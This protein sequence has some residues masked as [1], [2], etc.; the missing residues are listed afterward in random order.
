MDFLQVVALFND[1]PSS[2]KKTTAPYT[3]VIDGLAT[4]LAAYTNGSDYTVSQLTI[5]NA[6]YGWL[7]VWGLIFGIPRNANESDYNYYNRIIAVL[8]AIVGTIPGVEFWLTFCFGSGT[9]TENVGGL[10]Y[11]IQLPSSFSESQLE[12]FVT[13]FNYIR[14][15]GVPFSYT[16]VA[17]GMFLRTVNFLGGA[18]KMI[19]AYFGAVYNYQPLPF[20]A[21]QPSAVPLLPDLYLT[22]PTMNPSLAA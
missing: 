12:V 13:T 3:Q 5:A 1:L 4:Q 17:D 7:D 20:S 15:I 19:G 18:D 11:S 9:V 21:C 8:N 2:F 22:D 14:P 16:N 6:R 10:G